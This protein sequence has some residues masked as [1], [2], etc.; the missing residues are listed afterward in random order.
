MYAD[1][2]HEGSTP[3]TNALTTNPERW[4]NAST[5]ENHR[6]ADACPIFS[7]QSFEPQVEGLSSDII[8]TVGVPP[9]GPAQT[10][11]TADPRT[12]SPAQSI[13]TL[14]FHSAMSFIDAG[15][16][17]FSDKI[18]EHRVSSLYKTRI[19]SMSEGL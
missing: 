10:V 14:S 2:S 8:V 13:R 7:V 6:Q 12:S 5:V 15:S 18:S 4:S 19:T 3:H 1:K 11:F 9:E 17:N 16:H